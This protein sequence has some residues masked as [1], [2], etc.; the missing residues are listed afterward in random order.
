M[1]LITFKMVNFPETRAFRQIDLDVQAPMGEIMLSVLDAYGLERNQR[2]QFVFDHHII[3]YYLKFS[4]L[5]ADP[6]TAIILGHY[7]YSHSGDPLSPEMLSATN[8]YGHRDTSLSYFEEQAIIRDQAAIKATLPLTEQAFLDACPFP[9]PHVEKLAGSLNRNPYESTGYFAREGHIVRLQIKGGDASQDL[10]DDFSVLSQ[11]EVLIIKSGLITQISE[12]IGMLTHLYHLNLRYNE[13]QSIP[14]T[15]GNLRNLKSLYLSHN[16]LTDLPPSLGQLNS[17]HEI[18]LEG[19]LFSHIPACIQHLTSLE[20]LGLNQNQ[21][22]EV[23]AFIG[24]LQMLKHLVL[25]QNNISHL[26]ASISSL[27]ALE[28]LSL[29]NNLFSVLPSWLASLPALKILNLFGNLLIS[30]S[31]IPKDLYHHFQT[32][33]NWEAL[34]PIAQ[35]LFQAHDDDA[36]FQFYEPD[37]HELAARFAADPSTFSADD[38][39]RLISECTHEVKSFLSLHLPANS[40]LLEKIDLKFRYPTVNTFPILF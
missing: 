21:I 15:F 30:L 10:P 40:P 22:S 23:P 36:L 27:T 2:I 28:C 35:R 8:Q 37:A 20:G 18:I 13:L 4:L 7:E 16:Q 17:L 29:G 31:G 39:Y 9:I 19:N 38:R 32:S 14:E 12:S 33:L 26:P 34:P 5:N 6:A 1:P 25:S 3:P 24:K 11:L